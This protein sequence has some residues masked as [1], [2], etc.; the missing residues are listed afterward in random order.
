MTNPV[1]VNEPTVVDTNEDEGEWI[2]CVVGTGY[3][4]CTQ[5]PYQIRKTTTGRILT[6]GLKPNGYVK[7][8]LNGHAYYKHVAIAQQ[9]IP[10]PESKP[11]VDHINH[12]RSDNRLENLRWVT[13]SQNAKNK[14]G[15]MGIVYEYV[16]NLP[17]DAHQIEIYGKY[18]FVDYWYSPTTQQFFYHGEVAIRVL[19]FNQTNRGLRF[20]WVYDIDNH[21][22]KICL[23]KYLRDEGLD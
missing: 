14:S 10:N 3:E 6:E 17:Q 5:E 15:H 23:N 22:R 4:I 8:T 13:T 16:D 12:I 19:H 11:E 20:V 1:I 18:H 2:L 9:F 21:R 7:V